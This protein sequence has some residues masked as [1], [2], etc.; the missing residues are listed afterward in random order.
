MPFM[1]GSTDAEDGVGGDRRIDG[2]PAPREHLR[3]GLGGQ[4]RAG[5]DDAARGGDERSTCD[6]RH[7]KRY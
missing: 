7:G 2:V 3:P 5:G 1:N 4:R 6:N